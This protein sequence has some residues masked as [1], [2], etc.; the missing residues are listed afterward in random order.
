MALVALKYTVL[1]Y[2]WGLSRC[3]GTGTVSDHQPHQFIICSWA[4]WKFGKIGPVRKR[5]SHHPPLPQRWDAVGQL[6]TE[7]STLLAPGNI[8]WSLGCVDSRQRTGW[9][10]DHLAASCLGCVHPP[11]SKSSHR[12]QPPPLAIDDQCFCR[13]ISEASLCRIY[14][15]LGTTS[16]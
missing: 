12:F 10:E 4:L 7:D 3:L 9:L 14:L 13:R 5:L 15:G 1:Q 11:T 2:T 8:E 16:Q 6:C